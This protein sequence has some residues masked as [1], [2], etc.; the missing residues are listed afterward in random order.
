[1]LETS[2][3]EILRQNDKKKKIPLKR[4]VAASDAWKDKNSPLPQRALKTLHHPLNLAQSSPCDPDRTDLYE[5][6]S[7]TKKTSN[8]ICLI[9]YIIYN[10][11]TIHSFILFISFIIV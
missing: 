1:M 2:F 11:S 8:Y 10:Y 6:V 5:N 3:I 9:V 4:A 7:D